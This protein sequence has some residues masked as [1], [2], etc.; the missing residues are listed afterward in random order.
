M[1]FSFYLPTDIVFGPGALNSLHE[2]KLPGTHAL[3]VMTNGRSARRN[4]YIDRLINELDLAGANHTIYDKVSPNPTKDNVMEGSALAREMGCDF[5]VALGGGSAIDAAK[6]IAI[7]T[8]NEGDYWDYVSSGSGKGQPIPNLP[9]K[10]VVVTTTSGTG[11]EAG[12]GTVITNVELNEKI[13]FGTP[14]SFPAISIVDPELTLSVPPK[15]TAYQGFDVLFHATECYISK[16][17]NYAVDMIALDSIKRV[18]KYLP[19][20]VAD[21]SNLEART[22]MAWANILSGMCLSLGSLTVK[23]AMEHALSGVYQDL[24][25][26]AGLVLIC[27]DYY[28]YCESKPELRERM[29]DMARALGSKNPEAEGAFTAALEELMNT[30]GMGGLKMADFGIKQED[31][32]EVVRLTHNHRGFIMEYV[33]ITEADV[34]DILVN[35]FKR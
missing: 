9:L 20:A 11:S 22:E 3:V 31:F 6:A 29:A 21:G 14:N 24:T 18:A 10:I 4:G 35:S 19:A 33:E 15:F 17:R 12:R 28:K 8:T 26:G 25:H 32:P 7:M 13:G 30:C 27:L 5:I 34:M 2:K 23:H 16:A 1:N